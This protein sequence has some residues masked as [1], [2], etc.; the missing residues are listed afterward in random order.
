ML[1]VSST[2]R[3]FILAGAGV[4]AEKRH[5]NFRSVGGL[6]DVGISVLILLRSP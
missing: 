5:S 1:T 4:S 3:I 6:W 2:D